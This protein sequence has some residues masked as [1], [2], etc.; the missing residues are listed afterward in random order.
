M[1]SNNILIGKVLRELYDLRVSQGKQWNA[2]SYLKAAEV[3]EHSPN[4]ITSGKEARKLSGIGPKIATC[5]DTI[6][7]TKTV[8]ELAELTPKVGE[9]QL[10]T[11]PSSFTDQVAPPS[12]GEKMLAIKLFSTIDR[13]GP[14]TAEKWYQA[15]YRSIQDLIEAGKEK[16]SCTEGQW[17]GISLYSELSQRIPRDEITAISSKLR[18]YLDQ[19][20]ATTQTEPLHFEIAGSYRRGRLDSGDIDILV[21]N[22]LEG[23]LA[24]EQILACSIFTHTLAKGKKKYLGIGRLNENSLHRRIDVEVV[25]PEQY[26]FAICYFTGSASFNVQLRS[27]AESH[28]YRL[29]EKGLYDAKTLEPVINQQ[30]EPLSITTEQ[31]LLSF[32][33]LPWFEPNERENADL[34]T[35]P[36]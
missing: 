16:L 17:L 18:S 36:W 31:E 12:W 35:Y 20:A 25:I 10:P 13:V 27:R 19:V 2:R 26:P 22:R 6:L 5:V 11:F 30:G 34:S 8:P 33:H 9:V 4:E 32:L 15:G 14:V 29:N 7:A 3:I 21:L 28:G 1:S 24:M 23:T